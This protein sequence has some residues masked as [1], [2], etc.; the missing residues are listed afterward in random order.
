[1]AL[2]PP[3]QVQRRVRYVRQAIRRREQELEATGA[4][5]TF[6]VTAGVSGLLLSAFLLVLMSCGSGENSSSSSDGDAI[7]TTVVMEKRFESVLEMRDSYIEIGG[8]CAD[9]EQS[10]QVKLALE[11]G[12]CNE[13]NVMS[14]YSSRAVAD[15]Q[16]RAFKELINEIM[17]SWITEDRPISLLVG[18]NW[19]L[20]ESDASLVSAFQSAFGGDLIT[21]Y[22]DIP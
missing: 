11:S 17:P 13:S 4:S 1:V 14:I 3:S 5:R 16:N 21:S 8:S 19:I 2:T 9:W 15:E 20:N 22:R 12:E 7:P 6:S 10:N 18:A